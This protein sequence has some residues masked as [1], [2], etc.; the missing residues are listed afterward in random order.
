MSETLSTIDPITLEI[1]WQRLIAIM[2]EVDN[3]VVRTSF[4]TIVGESRDFA[5]IMTDHVGASLC[6]SS[7]S[8]PNFCVVLPRTSR[9]ILARF[10]IETLREGDVL[11]T[12]DAWL[13]TGHLPDYVVLIPIFW[14]GKVVAFTGI[15]AH[16]AD[17]GG[18]AG[19]I[20]AVDVFQEGLRLTP[21]K[22]YEGGRENDLLFEMIGNNCRF[23]ELVLG[24]LRAI[25]GAGWMAAQRVHEFL[26]DYGLDDLVALSTTIH[27]RSEQAM[28]SRIAALPDGIYEFGLDIDGYIDPV[29]LHA[30]IEIRGSEVFVDYSG[31]SSETRK[32]AINCTF[33]TTYASTMYPFKC[34]LVP[35][36]PNNEGLFRPIHVTAPEG[37]IL[38]CRYPAP[39][40]A[41]AKTT[42]NMNQVLFGALWPIFGEHAQ[43]GSGSIWPFKFF[44]EEPGYGRFAI[45]CLPHGGRGAMRELD[46]MAPIAFPHNSSV[47]PSEILELRAPILIEKKAL[48]ADSGGAGRRRGG[49]G[50]EIVVRSIATRPMTM[51]LRPDK[52]FFHPPGLNGG[53]PGAVG[54]VLLNGEELTRFPAL[55]FNPG[56]ELRLLM[57]GGGGFGPVAER[58][59][60][61]VQHD[62]A[63][64]YITSE[65]AAES[66]GLKRTQALP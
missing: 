33:N 35:D 25:A 55:Q 2:D 37:C 49:V 28:R 15:V 36:I 11:I 57:P 53:Q 31:S 13:G 5:V 60:T 32:A 6:Q 1:Q 18:H 65:S 54:R 42:N 45:H 48:R 30:R 39:V 64:G 7:F 56:D 29:H 47:T 66:Y 27:E 22:L 24:D 19:D 17:V 43:A 52:M 50:Q 63:M 40:K 4:S 14:R 41:R 16:L 21:C 26:A 34:A 20:E 3:A 44:G 51:L 61:M 59:T 23:P 10:P 46:G 9:H 62:L 38:N 58:P 12:N 8:P